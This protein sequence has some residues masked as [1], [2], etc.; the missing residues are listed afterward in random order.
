[1]RLGHAIEAFLA[2]MAFNLAPDADVYRHPDPQVEEAIAVI[3][4]VARVP[5]QEHKWGREAVAAAWPSLH[6]FY[7]GTV[8]SACLG[9]MKKPIADD[10]MSLSQNI[11]V[12]LRQR[13]RAKP[14]YYP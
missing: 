9:L 14:D 7:Y 3:E 13:F 4:A 12:W 10:I 8:I 5:Q 6:A 1:M 11:I 2:D